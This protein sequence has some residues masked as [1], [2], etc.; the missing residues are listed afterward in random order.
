[1][2]YVFNTPHDRLIWDVGHQAYGH[3]ILTGRREL[4]HTNRKLGGISGFPKRDESIYDAFGTGHSSTAISAALGMAV[5]ARL[6]SDS[7]RVHIAIVGDGA[8]SAGQAFEALNNA[9]SR[10]LKNAN[11]LI[12]INDNGMSIDPNLGALHEHHQALRNTSEHSTNWY[13]TLG[14]P[15]TGIVDGNNIEALLETLVQLKDGQGVRVLHC[16]TTKG[17]GYAKAES[18][19]TRLHATT[20]KIEPQQSSGQP[21]PMRYQEVFGHTLAELAQQNPLLAGITP[22]MLSGSSMQIM[23]DMLPERTFD[24]GIA[25]QHALTFAAGLACEGM[26]PFCNIYSTFL[27]RAYDQL[28]HDICLQQLRVV[29]CIDRAGLVGADGPTHHGAFDMAFLRCLPNTIIAAPMNELELRHL[30]FSAQTDASRNPALAKSVF[31]IRYPRG[32]GVLPQWKEPFKEIEVGTAR[33]L[34]KGSKVAILSV[35][36]IGNFVSEACERLATQQIL[37]S[38]ADMRFIKPLDEQLLHTLATTHEVLITVEDGCLKGGF[39]SAIA[40]WLAEHRYNNILHSMGLPDAF[41][42][43][44]EPAELYNLCGLSPAHIASVVEKYWV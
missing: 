17:K 15:Y 4:F 22:A 11:L 29:L 14:L 8:L 40:E 13:T 12:I 24:T 28:V 35:G 23:M 37:P 34:R 18:E 31:C 1:L 19:Q 25:E 16:S 44:G 39:G 32:Y 2:H 7:Q 20:G 36:H 26:L 6:Q 5:A 10:K 9:G 3:K 27:Q 43:Q 33:F 42:T 38:H 41:V 21:K 30:M